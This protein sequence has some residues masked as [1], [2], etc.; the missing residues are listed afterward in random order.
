MINK[1]TSAPVGLRLPSSRGAANGRNIGRWLFRGVFR[2]TVIDEHY[3]PRHG[4]VMLAA[5]HSGLLDGPLLFS[6]SPRPMHL[7]AKQSIFVPPI[8]RV[9]SGT[10]QIP[11]D[12][13]SADRTAIEL[14][15]GVL[16]DGRALG[17]FPE[18]HRGVGDFARLRHGIAYLHSRSQAP[19]VP[20]ALLGT[21]TTGM[22]K[23]GFPKPKS[24]LVVVFGEPFSVAAVGD[25]DRRSTLA[26]MGEQIR[27]RLADHVEIAQRQTGLILPTDDPSIATMNELKNRARR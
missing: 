3:V 8:D 25:I 21:R 15:M 22:G 1:I 5:N 12:Y 27:Q 23:E 7:L 24:P 2:L 9:L 14:A 13:E 17:I 16:S 6:A 18:A 26:A 10:G 19:I 20:V 11:L 4:R